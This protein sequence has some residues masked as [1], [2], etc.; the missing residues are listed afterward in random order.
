MQRK[1]YRTGTENKFDLLEVCVGEI[2]EKNEVEVVVCIWEKQLQPNRSGVS[3]PPFSQTNLKLLVPKGT[4]CF[5]PHCLGKKWAH[6][7]IHSFIHPS[8]FTH[9][10]PW[11]LIEP[12][13][14]LPDIYVEKYFSDVPTSVG[15]ITHPGPLPTKIWVCRIKGGIRRQWGDKK[16]PDIWEFT[17]IKGKQINCQNHKLQ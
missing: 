1:E 7:F 8:Q 4:K 2:S 11:W 3:P 17:S 14:R 10:H 5:Q 16:T 9:K 6:S 15:N 12:Y 13:P